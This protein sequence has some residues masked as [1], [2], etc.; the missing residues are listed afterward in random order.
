MVG[1]MKQQNIFDTPR[2]R[3]SWAHAACLIRQSKSAKVKRFPYK[4]ITFIAII[5][6]LL[7]LGWGGMWAGIY[8]I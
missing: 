1:G 6:I 5:F 7:W 2:G 3:Q 4:P 8:S